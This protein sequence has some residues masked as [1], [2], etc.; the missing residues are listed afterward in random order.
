MREL[1]ELAA[2]FR[3]PITHKGNHLPSQDDRAERLLMVLIT[4]RE[5]TP[6]ETD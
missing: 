6:E 5:G 3:P 4:G 2:P 1:L